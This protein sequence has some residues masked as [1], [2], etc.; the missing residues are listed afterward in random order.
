[1]AKE[2][3]FEK[4]ADAEYKCRQC[5]KIYLH[6]LSEENLTKGYSVDNASYETMFYATITEQ[7]THYRNLNLDQKKFQLAPN[8]YLHDCRDGQMGL[9]DLIGLVNIRTIEIHLKG[10]GTAR[11]LKEP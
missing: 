4:V 7:I 9:G 6:R 5:G 8:T 10:R 1:M 3:K 2:A 11:K